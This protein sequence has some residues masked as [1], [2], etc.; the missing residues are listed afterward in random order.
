M[1]IFLT[2]PR[3]SML[4]TERSFPSVK[5]V[6]ACSQKFSEYRKTGFLTLR[7]IFIIGQSRSVCN[8][9]YLTV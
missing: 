8:E 7:N 4:K 9:K 6:L 1:N 3:L 5:A 2:T